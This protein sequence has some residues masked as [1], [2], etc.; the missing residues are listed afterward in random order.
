M[1]THL[2]H[3]Y[4]FLYYILLNKMN[5]DGSYINS[6]KNSNY[7][8]SGLFNKVSKYGDQMSGDL[9]MQNNKIINIGDPIHDGQAISKSYADR[10][11]L[12][13]LFKYF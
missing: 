13:R 11:P 10:Q 7:M 1:M 2:I 12:P 8:Y 5:H 4:N 9:D 3:G 6:N